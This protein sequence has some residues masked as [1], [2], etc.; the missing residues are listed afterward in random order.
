MKIHKMQRIASIVPFYSSFFVLVMSMV[1]LKRRKASIKRWIQFYGLTISVAIILFVLN[2]F[3]V[4][5]Q[6]RA[7]KVI[8]SVA[9]CTIMNFL[10]IEIQICA[11]KECTNTESSTTPRNYELKST[12]GLVAWLSIS[13]AIT[14]VVVCI[15]FLKK[16]HPYQN[17]TDTNGEDNASLALI[18]QED[19]LSGG[20]GIYG[21]HSSGGVGFGNQTHVDFEWADKDYDRIPQYWGFMTGVQTLQATKI[22]AGKLIIKVDSTLTAGNA[23]II[24]LVDGEYYCHIPVN[25]STT[26]LLEDVAQKNVLVRMGCEAA[27]IDITVER[28][29]QE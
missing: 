9:I 22:D 1:E 6:M 21:K 26:I 29:I 23:E 8:G 24:I 27:E 4:P 28:T 7:V 13:L 2:N 5:E 11:G 3:L 15:A 12:I 16:P 14:I 25:E 20:M 17:Y 18:T 10:L 19:L